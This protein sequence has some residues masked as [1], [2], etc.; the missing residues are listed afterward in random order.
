MAVLNIKS[1]GTQISI[2]LIT[3]IVIGLLMQG[4]PQIAESYIKPVGT[5]FLNLLKFIVVPLVLFSVVCSIISMNDLKAL[6]KFGLLTIVYFMVTTLIAVT[7]GLGISTAFGSYYPSL[8]FESVDAVNAVNITLMD[9]LLSFFPKNSIEPLLNSQMMQV[10]VI[11]VL[12]AIAILK[13]GQ[14]AKIIADFFIAAN[15]V[16]TTILGFVISLAPIG[17]F[18]LI[19][20]VVAVNGPVVL[21]TFAA[22]IGITYLCFCIHAIV[23]YGGFVAALGKMSPVRFFRGMLPAM[24]F[25]FSSSSGLATLPVTKKC[26]DSLGVDEKISSFVLPLGATINMDGVAIYLGAAAVF[27]AYCCGI[28]LS[29][30]HYLSIAL[31]C[32]IASIGTPGIPGGALALMAMVFT[33]A[34]VPLEG[35]ALV[36]GIDRIIDMGRTTMSITGDA[37]CS[38]IINRVLKK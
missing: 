5:I 13:C 32:T 18:C 11:A 25:A 9:Q 28:D 22:L 21:G 6:G 37:S 30:H 17:V 33:A 23:V 16:T 38:V 36:A 29:I 1:L 19:C 3:G 14:K 27:I 20:P 8:S 24:L 34:E 4:C 10:I 2:S 15:E 7:L 35:V 26:T 12:I 31:A